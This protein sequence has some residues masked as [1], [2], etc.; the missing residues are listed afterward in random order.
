MPKKCHPKKCQV[1]N[2]IKLFQT[3]YRQYTVIKGFK[4][5]PIRLCITIA[6][7][8]ECQLIPHGSS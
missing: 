3:V 2:D 7:V 6:S 4:R 5:Y 8:L 1:I